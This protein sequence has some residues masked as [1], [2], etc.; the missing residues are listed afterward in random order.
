MSGERKGGKKQS[1]FFFI[2]TE[3]EGKK[4]ER[5]RKVIF[6]SAQPYLVKEDSLCIVFLHFNEAINIQPLTL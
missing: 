4:R 1:F 5:E 2:R 3:T 6:T